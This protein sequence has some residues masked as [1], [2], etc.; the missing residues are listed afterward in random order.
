[1]AGALAAQAP[2]A[3]VDPGYQDDPSPAQMERMGVVS[4]S[5]PATD[6][7]DY[8]R[9][10]AAQYGPSG[11]GGNG[12]LSALA[13]PSEASKHMQSMGDELLKDAP[14]ALSQ[15]AA[16]KDEMRQ[17]QIAAITNAM[18]ILQAANGRVNLPMLAIA[19]GAGAPT[20]T[21]SLGET[22]SNIAGA[23]PQAYQHDRQNQFDVAKLGIEGA[24][25]ASEGAKEG[26][27][28][29]LTRFGLG[30]QLESAA[31]TE[32]LRQL[33][34][35]GALQRAQIGADARTT[36]AGMG[37]AARI[38]AANIGAQGGVDKANINADARTTSAG[39]G[40]DARTT[41]A[42]I[43]AD[44]RTGAADIS[45]NK[46]VLVTKGPTIQVYDPRTRTFT[47]TGEPTTDAQRL[48]WQRNNGDRHLE[49]LQQNADTAAKKAEQGSW[50]YLGTDPDDPKKG[51]YMD[52][53]NGEL[54]TGQAVANAKGAAEPS[55]IRAARILISEKAAPD[56]PTAYGMVRSGVND[57]NVFSRLVQTE[58]KNLQG[59]PQGMAMTDK[60]AESLARETI[61]S[62]E[63]ARQQQTRAGAVPAP[64]GAPAVPLYTQKN[65]WTAPKGADDA[66]VQKEFAKIPQ[67]S[68][69]IN[70]ADGK[71]YTKK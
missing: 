17:R 55:Q 47:D 38:Q 48:E 57:V 4:R 27:Q 32:R 67:G 41:S 69:Y 66:T 58:K 71:P 23:L 19:Q 1:M 18:G 37:A 35:A 62:R 44:A 61:V 3:G 60:E 25:V 5:L 13:E 11:G 70:P 49:I 7:N 42:Q 9:S 15:A 50:Q 65:P 28:D 56:F 40:A 26:Y 14:G 64:G 29:F 6:P 52:H 21:G 59:T 2:I 39:I 16:K 68:V 8:L 53:H 46:Q 24:N 43:G 31:E 54:K 12:A 34:I 30:R 36:S 10:L 63:A 45:A 22:V 51:L 33:M 20:R